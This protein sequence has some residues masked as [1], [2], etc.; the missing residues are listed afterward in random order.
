VKKIVSRTFHQCHPLTLKPV[1][2]CVNAKAVSRRKQRWTDEEAVGRF[3]FFIMTSSS[4]GAGMAG[5]SSSVIMETVWTI[6]YP[7]LRLVVAGLSVWLS[8]AGSK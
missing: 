7:A 5:S 2:E 4:S 8:A 3:L 6:F 1:C